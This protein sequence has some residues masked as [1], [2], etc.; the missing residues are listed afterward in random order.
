M[1]SART[2][3]APSSDAQRY[4]SSL[5]QG[6]LVAVDIAHAECLGA[7]GQILHV[8]LVDVFGLDG[9]GLVPAGLQGLGPK[10][11]GLGEVQLQ[12]LAAGHCEADL[13]RVLLDGLDH[14]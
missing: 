10:V 6:E 5:L 4:R 11:E 8:T 1:N 7:A 9:D 2:E 3:S 12:R 13:L 14:R